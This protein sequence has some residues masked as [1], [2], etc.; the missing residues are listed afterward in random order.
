M[1]ILLIA[2]TFDST[3]GTMMRIVLCSTYILCSCSLFLQSFPD[4]CP[5]DVG[6]LGILKH[7]PLWY[8]LAVHLGVP[9]AQVNAYR[10]DSEMGGGMC[11]LYWRDGC[12][13]GGYPNTWGFLLETVK[14]LCMKGT[15][16]GI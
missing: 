1:P 3:D 11:L 8:E 4:K 6:V 16:H 5:S 12:C 9:N 10:L 13:G 15:K 14:K 7:I 2:N